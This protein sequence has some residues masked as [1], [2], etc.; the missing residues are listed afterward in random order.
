MSEAVIRVDNATVARGGETALAAVS[1]EVYPNEFVGI[2]GPNGAGK[3]TLLTLLNGLCPLSGGTVAILGMHPHGRDA[4]R[5][6]RRV[7]YVPQATRIDPRLP[8]KVRETVL[9]GCYG[10]LGW[11]RRPSAAERREALDTLDWVGA[12]HLAERP[13]GQLSGGE[14]QRVA[15]ARALMQRPDVFLFDEPTASID[16]RAQRDVLELIQH[17]HDTHHTTALYVT[18]ELATL[19]QSCDRLLLMKD[20]R[21]WREGAP[22][23]MLVD[24]LLEELYEG[25]RTA[26][27]AAASL[28]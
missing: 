22:R 19:P 13:L 4:H 12:G 3:T 11:L 18:H 24:A 27:P 8:I 1:L 16:P 14:F 5:V 21:I 10:R 9:A 20:G 6:R 26:W 25:I 28:R 7:A 2:I 15:I 23:D 17:I